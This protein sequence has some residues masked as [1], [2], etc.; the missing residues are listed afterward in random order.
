ME[1][2]ERTT[3]KEALHHLV[4]ALPDE[5]LSA[6]REAI[7]RLADL[8]LLGLADAPIDVEPESEEEREAVAEALE[9]VAHGRVRSWDDVRHELASE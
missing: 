6:A 4:D 3:T 8:F 5:K 1:T 2:R 7:E 9:D